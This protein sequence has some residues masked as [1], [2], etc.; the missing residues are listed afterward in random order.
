[1]QEVE[2]DNFYEPNQKLNKYADFA[3]GVI[4]GTLVTL[5]I[6]GVILLWN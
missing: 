3:I 1:M 5:L 2:E 4:F 6:E